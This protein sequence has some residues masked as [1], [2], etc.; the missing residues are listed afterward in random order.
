MKKIITVLILLTAFLSN[1]QEQGNVVLNWVEKKA[2][3]YGDYTYTIPQ[4][5]HENFQFD[6]YNRTLYFNLML[7]PEK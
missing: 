5:N 2:F 3:S 7:T 4:F 1:S 6:N